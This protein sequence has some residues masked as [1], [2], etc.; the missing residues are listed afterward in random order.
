MGK[1]ISKSA[2]FRKVGYNPHQGQ[3]E[4]HKSPARF[5]VTSAGRRFGKS[6]LGGFELLPEAYLAYS[7][8]TTLIDEGKRREFWI[9][10]PE[11]SDAEKEFRHLYNTLKKLDM[12]FDRPGTYNDPLGGNLHISL[13]EGAFQVHGKSAKHPETLVGEGLN[14]VILG[15]AAKLKER[16]WIKHIRPMLADYGGWA[17]MTSTPEGKNWFHRMWQYG[18]DP[19]RPDWASWRRPSWANPFVYKTPTTMEAVAVAKKMIAERAPL[20]ALME[21]KELDLEVL[22]LLQDMT[23]QA[24]DQE[25]GA[26][27]SEFVGRVFSEFDEEI[28]VRDFSFNPAY[29]TYA[30]ADYGFTNP[31]VWLLL[32]VD[33]W[34][35]VYVLD[36]F[37]ETQ[38]T[39]EEAAHAIKARG[40][41]PSSTIRFYGDPA[42]PSDH[43]TLANILRIKFGGNTGGEIKDRVTA[44]KRALKLYPMEAPYDQRKPALIFNR[45]CVNCIREFSA[46]RY[47]ERRSQV[48][49][50]N[51]ENP[52]KK[53]DHTPEALGR[54]FAGH[55][56]AKRRRNPAGNHPGVGGSRSTKASMGR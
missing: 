25:I 18:Q 4:I 6:Q 39:T 1:Y 5:K 3:I 32:Q 38:H 7:L 54:F 33:H 42:G 46:Y 56:L 53:D 27:F 34:G 36:E 14:G 17:Q 31:F 19:L 13:W 10:G 55:I 37:Y 23:E 47:P 15:E 8:R 49:L 16:V 12:P 51:T 9:V 52:Q 44:I 11:Y 26:D 21:I 45:K 43:R 50:N 48:D 2:V 41:A 24:F 22:S 30:C 28:H 35:N 20:E 29:E 40:L